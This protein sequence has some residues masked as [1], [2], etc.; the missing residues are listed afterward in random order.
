MR[1]MI[2]GVMIDT[3]ELLDLGVGPLDGW[4]GGSIR[5]VGVYADE[6]G[7]LY[8]HQHNPEPSGVWPGPVGDVLTRCNQ[9]VVRHLVERFELPA[10]YLKAAGPGRTE[11]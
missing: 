6:Q 7:R 2:D 9:T 4:M 5:L 1:A 8:I 3:A 11:D 10:A